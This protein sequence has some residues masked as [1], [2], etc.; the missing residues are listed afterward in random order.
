MLHNARSIIPCLFQVVFKL[1]RRRLLA[2][3]SAE[4]VPLVIQYV[5]YCRQLLHLLI[6]VGKIINITFGKIGC[7][8]SMILFVYNESIRVMSV[9]PLDWLDQ[10]TNF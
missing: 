8:R 4:K 7:T 3:C 2:S 5:G 6:D 9:T 10:S 1:E